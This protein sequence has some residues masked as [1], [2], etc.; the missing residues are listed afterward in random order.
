MSLY[1]D[2]LKKPAA[3]SYSEEPDIYDEQPMQ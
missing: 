2:E 1:K 3:D